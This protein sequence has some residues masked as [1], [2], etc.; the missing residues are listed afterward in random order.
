MKVHMLRLAWDCREG[1]P[2]CFL[3][4]FPTV[5]RDLG[6]PVAHNRDLSGVPSQSRLWKMGNEEITDVQREFVRTVTEEAL[7]FA[8]EQGIPAPD[9]VFRPEDRDISSKR[10]EQRLVA[11]KT[12]EVWQQAEP[13][14]T[15]T[16]YLSGPR[17]T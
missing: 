14:V 17:T 10:S 16:F 8:R 7:V 3:H 9:P 15:D 2:H 1:F 12:K 6:F 4:S 5:C 13:F 11:A